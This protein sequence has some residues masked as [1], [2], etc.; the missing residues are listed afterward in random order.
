MT[1]KICTITAAILI[2][3]TATSVHASKLEVNLENYIRAETDVQFKEYAEKAGGPGKF[4]HMREPFSVKNQTTI[5][6]NRDTL[7]SMGVFD[8]HKPITIT[9]P[10]PSGRF[11]SMLVID[12]DMYNPV[13]K[14]GGGNVT[15]SLDSVGTR[16]VLVLFRTFADPN[17]PNDMKAA[18]ALQDAISVEQSSLGKL[19]LPDWDEESLVKTRKAVNTLASKINDFSNGYGKRGQVDPIMHLAACAMGWGGNPPRGAKYFVINPE[20]NDGKT[21]HTLT[22]PKDVPVQAFW[23]VTVYNKDGFFTPNKL[24]GYVVNNITAGPNNDGSVTIHFGGDPSQPNYLPITDGWNYVIRLY[25]PEWQILEG[26]WLP[27]APQPV[28]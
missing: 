10:D 14:T 12:Q 1:N 3:L 7:Y 26:N 6:G 19:D 28:K 15:L 23:S 18:H 17:D 25:L 22:M 9:K 20:K 8:L 24:N 5:R 11:Q 21:A 13:L 27:P 4:L 16:Y 2:F